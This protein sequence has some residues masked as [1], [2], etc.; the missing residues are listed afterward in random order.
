VDVVM[1]RVGYD[2]MSDLTLWRL[3]I[4]DFGKIPLLGAR[5][6]ATVLASCT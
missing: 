6:L 2:L 5:L 4:C 3:A 1:R